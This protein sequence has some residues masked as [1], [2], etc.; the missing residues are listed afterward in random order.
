[1]PVGMNTAQAQ[2]QIGAYSINSTND[3][4]V[5]RFVV[6]PPEIIPYSFYDDLKKGDGFFK[7]A[8]K[9]VATND[10]VNTT[11]TKKNKTSFIKKAIFGCLAIA[12][13]ILIYKKWYIIV[14][15]IKNLKK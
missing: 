2:N 9:I 13:G 7:D 4:K 6:N 11:S 8:L 12:T 15:F 10:Y 1:M 14:N 3:F 5:G